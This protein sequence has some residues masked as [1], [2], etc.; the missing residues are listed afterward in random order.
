LASHPNQAWSRPQ[1]IQK[2]WGCDYVGDGRVVDV[3]I[4]QLRKK[5][6]VDASIPEFIKTVRGYGYK[7]EAP[8]E[9]TNS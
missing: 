2:I 4:G 9:N 7:F 6:E 5:M 3:H 8:D 1:L